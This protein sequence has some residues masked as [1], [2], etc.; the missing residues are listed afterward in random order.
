MREP[1][2]DDLCFDPEK[3][4]VDDLQTKLQNAA[5]LDNVNYGLRTENEELIHQILCLKDELDIS[6]KR[7]EI[8]IAC[9]CKLREQ[10]NEEAIKT[11]EELLVK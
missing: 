9:L 1:N 3:A 5:I 10:G 2:Y 4:K 7:E 6:K 11:L 8:A